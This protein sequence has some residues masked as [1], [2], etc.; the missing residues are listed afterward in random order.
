M[1]ANAT[2]RFR[3]L[4]GSEP[5]IL[6]RV[7][8]I[9][10]LVRVAML[11]VFVAAEYPCARV[12]GVA[13][14]FVILFAIQLRRR[15]SE[16]PPQRRAVLAL[17][18][19]SQGFVIGAS[20]L[21]GGVHSPFLFNL[22]LPALIAVLFFGPHHVSRWIA[23]ASVLPA[24]ALACLPEALAGPALPRGPYA[25]ATLLAL[26]WNL[27]VLHGAAT[28][29]MRGFGEAHHAIASLRDEYVN[30]LQGNSRR[31]QVIG[32]KLADE[33]KNPLAAIKGLC[34][35]VARA[36]ESDRTRERLSVTLSEIDRMERVLDDY[37]TFSRPLEAIR[38]EPI[39]L[40]VVVAEVLDLLAV[41]AARRG[42][43]LSAH[44][45]ASLEGDRTCLKEALVGLVSEAIDATSAGG[46]VS[47]SVR[48]DGTLVVIEIVE[49]GHRASGS[50]E[51]A[52]VDLQPEIPAA[53]GAITRHG[54][55]LTC[56]GELG[57]RATTIRLPPRHA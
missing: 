14:L 33:L 39:E 35:L 17:E 38:R 40:G 24:I 53:L 4:S 26:L 45:V 47:L 52:Q 48:H 12:A 25:A 51:T 50:R 9:G 23:L 13:A 21:T 31:L 28:S 29:I 34:Q 5:R 3:S 27:F 8:W 43:A 57:Q 32:A 36:P 30:Q 10:A 19:C 6:H 20:A 37:A 7:M 49:I 16:S 22:V 54:G 41:R 18:L 55:T 42:V 46:S 44:G 15:R 11:A 56:S 1:V 2:N